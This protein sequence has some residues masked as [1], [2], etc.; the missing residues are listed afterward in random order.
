MLRALRLRLTGLYLA[1]SLG[2]VS[3]LGAGSYGLMSLYFQRSTDMALQYKMATEFQSRGLSLPSELA[4]AEQSW[5]QNGS[6]PANTST[7][8]VVS[9]SDGGEEEDNPQS[10]LQPG[11]SQKSNESMEEDRYNSSLAPIFVVQPAGGSPVVGVPVVNNQ[12]AIS[13]ALQS[14]SDIRTIMQDDG[15]NVRL[16]TYRIDSRTVLQVGRLLNDQDLLLSQYLS[17]LIILGLA[18]SLVLSL[19]SWTLAGSTIK[20]TQRAWDQQQQFISNASHELRTPLTLLRASADYALRSPSLDER[21]KSLRDILN[22]CDYMNRMVED[23][24]LLSQIDAHHLVVAADIVSLPE[25]LSEVARQVEKLA[26]VKS[27]TLTLEPVHGMVR[28]DQNRLRQ[29]VLILLDNALRFTPAGGTIRLGAVTR[30][31]EVIVHVAD[32]GSGIPPEHL[33]NIFERFYQVPGQPAEGRGNGLGLSIARGL[34][35]AQHGKILISSQVG[36]GTSVQII[37]PEV[38]G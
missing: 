29:V 17:G 14:G 23:L 32:S 10:T 20:P 33:R 7:P 3:V 37:L 22:E 28:G 36:K 16:L 31:R 5:M 18:A 26:A 4:A 27:V 13:H 35:E 8:V 11:I 9:A 34:V 30:G 21:E 12:A 25:L 38:G 19:A 1:A 2:L 24:L 15:T 6:R